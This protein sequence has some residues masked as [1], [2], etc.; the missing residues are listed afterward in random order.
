MP[1]EAIAP[2]EEAED[3]REGLLEAIDED[4]EL[5]G[6]LEGPDDFEEDDDQVAYVQMEGVLSDG[7]GPIALKAMR[8]TRL[9]VTAKGIYAYMVAL[10]GGGQAVLPG[11]ERVLEE[12]GI[13]KSTY[14]R[15]RRSLVD[16]GY[17]KISREN[18]NP[19]TGQL[20]KTTFVICQ[21]VAYPTTGEKK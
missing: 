4:M 11:W 1:S 18:G 3:A 8:D 10:T 19:A 16:L 15:H 17:V 21:E 2:I 7:F 9:N 14:Y 6:E 13:S 20:P 12:L 5:L